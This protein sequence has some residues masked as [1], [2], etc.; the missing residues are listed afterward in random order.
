MLR[1]QWQMTLFNLEDF[2]SQ[3]VIQWAL[4][5]A[6]LLLTSTYGSGAAPAA[7]N[8]SGLSDNH[9]LDCP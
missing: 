6:V 2:N 9:A 1:Q 7:A 3:T 5:D 4:Y 8:R